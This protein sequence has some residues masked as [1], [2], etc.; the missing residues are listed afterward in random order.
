MRKPLLNL[1]QRNEIRLDTFRGAQLELFLAR[2]RLS[3]DIYRENGWIAMKIS[4]W[5]IDRIKLNTR[6]KNN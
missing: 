2:K 4:N 3:R 5:L 6:W 1:E